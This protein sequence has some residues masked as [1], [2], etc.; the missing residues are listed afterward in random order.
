MKYLL[1]LCL[2]LF[3]NFDTIGVQNCPDPKNMIS[4]KVN[5]PNR[6]FTLQVKPDSLATKVVIIR[7]KGR[8][9]KY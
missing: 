7:K 9:S 1:I 8:T 4:C 6:R 2:S 3:H 5:I